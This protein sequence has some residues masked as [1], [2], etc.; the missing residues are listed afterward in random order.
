MDIIGQFG[1]DPIFEWG[2][3]DITT[4]DHTLRRIKKREK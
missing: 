3:G 2:N 4:M 1:Y